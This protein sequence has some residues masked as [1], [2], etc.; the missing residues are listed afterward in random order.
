MLAEFILAVAPN[1]HFSNKLLMKKGKKMLK[2]QA[3]KV[4]INC[5]SKKFN[6]FLQI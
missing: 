1:N 6:P 5:F 3:R 2:S 4:Q